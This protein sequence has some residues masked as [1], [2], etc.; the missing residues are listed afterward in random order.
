MRLY[1]KTVRSH[2]GCHPYNDSV[3]KIAKEISIIEMRNKWSKKRVTSVLNSNLQPN[4]LD[5]AM[6]LPNA[7]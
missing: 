1:E 7:N 5:K 2:L 4:A 3:S 6:N